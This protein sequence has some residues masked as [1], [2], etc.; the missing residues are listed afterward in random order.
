MVRTLICIDSSHFNH[1]WRRHGQRP[2]KRRDD[3]RNSQGSRRTRACCD[4]AQPAHT[5]S[6]AARGAQP[7]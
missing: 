7:T 1:R 6:D 2:R 3:P 4:T 5:S